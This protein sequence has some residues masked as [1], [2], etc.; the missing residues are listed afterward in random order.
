MKPERNIAAAGGSPGQPSPGAPAPASPPAGRRRPLLIIGA[1]VALLAAGWGI[2]A[3]LVAGTEGTDD[4]QIDADVVSIGPRVPG[5]VIRVLVREN[6]PVKKGDLLFELDPADYAA[7][8]QQAEA[9]LDLAVSQATVV[10][11]SARGGLSTAQA[12]LTA[13]AA[14][15]AGSA[16]QVDAARAAVTRAEAEARRAASDLERV[17]ALKAGDAISQERFDSVLATND[18]AQAALAAARAQLTSAEEGRRS[19]EGRV[20]EAAGRLVVSSPIDAQIAAAHARVRAA[21]ATLDL[22]R[23]QL[24]YTRVSAPTDGVLSRLQAREGGLVAAGQVMAQLVPARLYVTAN[25]KETQIGQMRPGQAAEIEIDAFPGTTLRGK[26]ESLSGGTGARFALLPPDN[27]SG[28][29]VKVV[30]RVP[31]RIALDAPPDGI[32]LRAGLSAFATVH[33]R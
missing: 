20:R 21:Q 3:L 16:A 32:P 19:A 23:N 10:E 12:G 8:V 28:N 25:F 15:L 26:V 5:Q 9:D 33:L 29:F 2:H 27:A 30:E 7:R 31:V 6:Q 17:R 24:A 13:S 11:A 22:A 1:V 18:A 14:G 4:A